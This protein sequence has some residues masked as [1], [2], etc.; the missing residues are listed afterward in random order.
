[1][2]KL[3]NILFQIGIIDKFKHGFTKKY[4]ENKKNKAQ[5]FSWWYSISNFPFSV[6]VT[7]AIF[8]TNETKI[9]FLF[10]TTDTVIPKNADKW[11][12]KN[13]RFTSIQYIVGGHRAVMS[14]AA[15]WFLS[16]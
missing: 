10:G 5:M 1:M 4:L 6:A 15:K 16:L 3:S 14:G 2:I 8:D 12:S 9:H 11:F 13:L 7:N